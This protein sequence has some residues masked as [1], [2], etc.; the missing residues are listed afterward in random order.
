LK[1][2]FSKNGLLLFTQDSLE[3]EPWARAQSVPSTTD[4]LIQRR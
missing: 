2:S 3:V 4:V 1:G